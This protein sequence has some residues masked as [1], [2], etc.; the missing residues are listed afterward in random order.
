[1][2][3]CSCGPAVS[4]DAA[5]SKFAGVRERTG[6]CRIGP[7]KGIADA[8]GE[9]RRGG[10]EA[11]SAHERIEGPAGDAQRVT[12]RIDDRVRREGTG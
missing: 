7:Q 2:G 1:M 3:P 10:A 4:R 6:R 12:I 8:L 5:A 11:G 9:G